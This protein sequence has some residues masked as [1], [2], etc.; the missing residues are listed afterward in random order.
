MNV[1][2]NG[3]PKSGNHALVK[4]VQLLGQPCEVNHATFAEGL[5][6]GTTHHV[7]IVRDPR[8]IIV[9]WLRFNRQPV[10]PGMFLTTFRKFQRKSL[11]EEMREF[12]GWLD[13]ENTFLVKYEDLIAD[14]FEM[15]RIASRLGVPYIAGAFNDLPNHTRTW[16]S[17][18][19]DYRELWKREVI[20]A[21]YDE[22]GGDLLAR[23]GY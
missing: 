21:W 17:V 15:R 23:W 9:S 11:A 1:F 5:P 7:F 6:E 10:T 13:D 22:G 2:C 12:E 16:N 20:D 19:S 4:A 14:P 3:F 8:D 18:H